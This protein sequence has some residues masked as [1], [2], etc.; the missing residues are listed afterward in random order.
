MKSLRDEPIPRSSPTKRHKS[1]IHNVICNFKSPSSSNVLNDRN[2]CGAQ[3]FSSVVSAEEER[4][5]GS[6]DVGLNG[7][8][9]ENKM[10]DTYQNSKSAVRSYK[11]A[12]KERRFKFFTKLDMFKI[13]FYSRFIFS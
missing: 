10:E 3:K 11:D 12:E 2:A 4:E 6:K 7:A 1:G 13:F 8:D 9:R 5:K